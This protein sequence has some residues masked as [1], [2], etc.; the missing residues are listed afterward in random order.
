MLL[1]CS[2]FAQDGVPVSAKWNKGQQFHYQIE[3]LTTE[4]VASGRVDTLAFKER[5]LTV[6]VLDSAKYGYLLQWV[7]ADSTD[8]VNLES[9][10]FADSIKMQYTTDTHGSFNDIV[11]WETIRKQI[12]DVIENVAYDI[13]NEIGLNLGGRQAIQMLMYQFG[14]KAGIFGIYEDD[15]KL[16]H[17]YYGSN[18]LLNETISYDET[19]PVSYADGV[20]MGKGS[21]EM[22][23]EDGQ[24]I[25][26]SKSE[27]DKAALVDYFIEATK[28]LNGG[29]ISGKEK[30]RIKKDEMF[31]GEDKRYVYSRDDG[32][33]QNSF[34]KRSQLLDEVLTIETI[35][36]ELIQ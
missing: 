16:M 7:F 33:L 23:K 26:D 19:F 17:Y 30:K 31:I 9:M 10:V 35:R 5:Y 22:R 3:N 20:V 32:S 15:L 34:Y 11:N 4:Q 27:T 14:S 36:F 28:E 8:E 6:T 21:F 29:R 25:I 2:L 18:Y 13:D 1:G 24:M 12:Y